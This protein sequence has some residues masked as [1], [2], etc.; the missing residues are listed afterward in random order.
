MNIS[1]IRKQLSVASYLIAATIS[2]QAHAADKITLTVPSDIN[3]ACLQM[4][5]LRHETFPA[6]RDKY[7]LEFEVITLPMNQTPVAVVNREIMVGSCGGLSTVVNA[8]NKGAK[9][10]LVF[11]IGMK[12]ESYQLVGRPNMSSLEDLRGKN[13]GIP[14]IQA[15]ASEMI[16]VIM[17]R[18]ANMLPNR[19]YNLVS[20]GNSTARLAAYL[21]GS[22]DALPST[23]PYSFELEELGNKILAESSTYLPEGYASSYYIVNRT[24][25]RENKELLVRLIKAMVETGMWIK[26]PANKQTTIDWFAANFKG[27]G[28][29]PIS[30][31]VAAKLYHYLF[32]DGERVA[33][34]LYAPEAAVRSGMDITIERGYL[35]QAE[36]PNPLGALIDY[37]YLN[38]ALR[39][40][41]MP[42]VVEFPK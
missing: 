13:I 16:E 38:E 2:W 34:N 5:M 4:D 18:G 35:T 23:Q 22:I 12:T 20:A 10:M 31:D 37:S 24:W 29:K 42:E 3:P 8:W 11:A 33:F 32:E 28:G 19:D 36:V 25:A 14:A 40:L 41:G 15:V 9:D 27:S 26:D 7:N 30:K 6:I 1:L 21:A 39:E 17:K